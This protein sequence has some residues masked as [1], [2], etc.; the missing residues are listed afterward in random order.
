MNWDVVAIV[1]L[2]AFGAVGS[3]AIFGLI[4][5]AIF[6]LQNVDEDE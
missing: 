4:G 5:W 2:M 1:F 6:F 3:I